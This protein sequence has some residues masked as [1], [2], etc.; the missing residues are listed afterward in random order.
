MLFEKVGETK[1]DWDASLRAAVTREGLVLRRCPGPS[2]QREGSAVL[3]RRC[4][5]SLRNG[6]A[7]RPPAS[8]SSVT[9]PGAALWPALFKM[10]E[11]FDVSVM[12]SMMVSPEIRDLS[13]PRR[14]TADTEGGWLLLSSA[15]WARALETPPIW[16]AASVRFDP[17][18]PPAS[19]AGQSRPGRPSGRARA[20]PQAERAAARGAASSLDSLKLASRQPLSLFTAFTL[21]QLRSLL[22][23]QC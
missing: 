14:S 16:R 5:C 17:P 19:P 9:H 6:A 8:T 10:V 15:D 21:V 11:N 4:L 7:C 1:R 13:L 20:R 12:G 3:H 2:D 23:S 22:R 18:A